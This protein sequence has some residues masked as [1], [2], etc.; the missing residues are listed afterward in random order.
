MQCCIQFLD[1]S[2]NV[3]AAASPRSCSDPDHGAAIAAD[4]R[5]GFTSLSGLDADLP[6]APCWMSAQSSSSRGKSDRAADREPQM[7]PAF[8]T[9]LSGRCRGSP[10]RLPRRGAALG[11]SGAE[12]REGLLGLLDPGCAVQWPAA[13]GGQRLL[14]KGGTSLSK[15]FGLISRFSEDIDVTVFRDDLGEAATVDELEALSGKKRRRRLDAIKG[16]EPGLRERD[17]APAG[18][19]RWARR[20]NRGPGRWS[21]AGG[22]RS[23]RRASR[24]GGTRSGRPGPAKL[25]DL[26]PEGDGG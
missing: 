11:R 13:A 23:G 1:G 20:W 25:A 6:A 4:L 8:V 2:A 18:R 19:G 16:R 22:T 12:R 7:N 5:E 21:A 9:F 3:I 26:V 15:G 10:R 17:D 14:F 24:A